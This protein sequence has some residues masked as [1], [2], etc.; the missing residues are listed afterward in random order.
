MANK[1]QVEQEVEELRVLRD[2]I[3]AYEE[4][5]VNRMKKIR[6]S[7]LQNRDFLG[8]ITQLFQ[9]VKASYKAEI[10]RL[11]KKNKGKEIHTGEA[12][13]AAFKTG[14]TI[15]K[16]L[17]VLMSANTGLYGDILQRTFGLFMDYIMG[18]K[19]TDTDIVIMGALGRRLFESAGATMPYTYFDFTSETITP[20]EV[21]KIIDFLLKYERIV[22]FYGKFQSIVTQT[23][24]MLDMYGN[25]DKA[26]AEVSTGVPQE[27]TPIKFFFEPSLP[28]V[29]Q[30][31]ESEIFASIFNQAIYEF[32]LAKL[33]SRIF[34]LDSSIEN[35]K[36]GLKKSEYDLKV[37]K[38]REMNKKQNATLSGMA[39]W[40][41]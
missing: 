21:L 11:L 18:R 24:T 40:G 29:M 27:H 22:L 12:A 10:D 35:M 39:L 36:D 7:T 25:Q 20:G 8:S 32:N 31:F 6:T 37:L 2:M 17:C 5:A 13:S 30:F 28:N 23:A 14:S 41:K 26:I 3:Q 15:N 16:T 33:G 38:H 1:K 19:A 4:I 9:E 34:S